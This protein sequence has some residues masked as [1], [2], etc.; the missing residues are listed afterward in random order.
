MFRNWQK[1]PPIVRAGKQ[2]DPNVQGLPP[3]GCSGG[4]GFCLLQKQPLS[5]GCNQLN[6]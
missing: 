6:R 5:T 3:N 1:P 4:P 2:V